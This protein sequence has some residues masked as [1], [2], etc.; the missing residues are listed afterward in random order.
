MKTLKNGSA[1]VM[2]TTNSG[3]LKNQRQWSKMTYW[4]PMAASTPS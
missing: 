3:E 2:C 4:S 1:D